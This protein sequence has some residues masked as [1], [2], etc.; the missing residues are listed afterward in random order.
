MCGICGILNFDRRQRVDPD[1]LQA[2][3]Q[4]MLH[5]GPDDAGL[6]VSENVGLAM[7]RLSIID[8][9][10][11]QQPATNEDE[12][13]WLV[14]NG[15]IYNHQEL[16]ERLERLGHRYR[17]RSDTETIVH[18][19]EEYGRDCVQ[20]LRGMFAFAL[21]DAR[22][23]CLFAARDRLGIKPFYYRLTSS[24]MQFG[25]EIKTILAYPRAS[26]TLNRGGLPEYLAFGYLSGPETLFECIRKLPPGHTLELDETGKI[27]IHEY[28]DL[29]ETPSEPR[30][31]SF[32]I[33]GY[34]DRLEQTVRSHLMSD[35]PLGVFLSGGLDSSVVAA[36]MTRICGGQIQTFSVGYDEVPFSELPYAREVA[37]YVGSEHHEVLVTRQAF[38]DAL[39]RLIWHED[40]PLVWP[41]SVPLQFVAQLARDHVTVV[42]TGEGSDETL[43]GYTRYPWTLWNT[44]L[45]R[46]YRELSPKRLRS[47]VRDSIADSSYLGAQLRRKLQHTFLGLDGE[48]WVSFYFD[49]FYSAFSD[50][51]QR[52]L[53]DDELRFDPGAAY[54]NGLVFWERSSGDLLKRLLYTDIKTYLVELLMKQDNMSMAASVE[55]RVPF[56]D[57]VLVEFAFNIP[58]RLE[59][60]GLAGK[61]ILKR[62]AE[63]LLPKSILYRQKMGFPTPWSHWLTGPQLDSIELLLLQPRSMERGLFRPSAIRRLFHEHR[64]KQ[65]DHA[66]RIW[67]LLNL[68]LWQRVFMDKDFLVS[69]ASTLQCSLA[70][71]AIKTNGA[72]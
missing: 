13:V 66:N 21:W 71:Q 63:D 47:V 50:S 28:W 9:K 22:R 15:E 40:E 51:N 39:P 64:Q 20:Y 31:A 54:R 43:A 56:L 5:R 70:P 23:R 16:R 53:L 34:R 44:R 6:Y 62:A 2:M 1:V 8:L 25:S 10:T 57:H 59:T 45:D 33:Q 3:N 58:S 7:R 29:R 35:V 49:N 36:L 18:L 11:G 48:S 41:S 52:V 60:K 69:Q 67:R 32:Y 46:I 26:A 24:G 27:A 65:R 19:Y 72:L 12:T 17:S 55:S 4:Q 14:Y 30:P 42:L 68:E 61:H 37:S 38:F